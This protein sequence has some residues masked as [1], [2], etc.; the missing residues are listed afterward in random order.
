VDQLDAASSQKS[1]GCPTSPSALQ[2]AWKLNFPLDQ[3]L[4]DLQV[5]DCHVWL[6]LPKDA[7]IILPS[8]TPP[9][10]T[11]QH[12]GIPEPDPLLWVGLYVSVAFIII[13]SVKIIFN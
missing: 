6:L 12:V 8:S 1:P 7:M 3:L 4:T 13:A 2:E 5:V 11:A 10:L 9:R